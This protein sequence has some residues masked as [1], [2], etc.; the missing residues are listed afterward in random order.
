[1][2]VITCKEKKIM[3]KIDEEE[4]MKF[5]L[6]EVIISS[7]LGRH[8]KKYINFID[9][10]KNSDDSLLKSQASKFMHNVYYI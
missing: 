10:M 4:R 2:E 7:L 9:V 8:S 1:M 6:D 3:N 5:L